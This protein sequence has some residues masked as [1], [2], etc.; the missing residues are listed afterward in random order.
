MRCVSILS[1]PRDIKG[2]FF[3]VTLSTHY[4]HRVISRNEIDLTGYITVTYEMSSLMH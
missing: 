2:F 1:L 3:G 4:E